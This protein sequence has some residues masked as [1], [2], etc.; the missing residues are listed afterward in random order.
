MVFLE[1]GVVHHGQVGHHQTYLIHH[2]Q[3]GNIQDR[4]IQCKKDQMYRVSKKNAL[5]SLEANI[6]GLKA[7]I[8]KSLISFENCMFSAFI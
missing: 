5:W 8:G 7:P 1:H 4:Q 3:N 6:S 2:Y